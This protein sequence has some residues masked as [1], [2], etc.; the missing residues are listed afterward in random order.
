MSKD[1]SGR[2]D[3]D[4]CP[5]AD[6][7]IYYL[8]GRIQHDKKRFGP[9]FIGNWE[10]DGFSFLFFSRP[11]EKTVAT[12][13]DADPALVLMDA[14]QM[15]Y[16]Q[17]QGQRLTPFEAGGLRIIPPWEAT[18]AETENRDRQILLDPGV[19][20]GAGTHTTTQDCLEALQ[21]ACKDGAMDRVL[22]L[23]TGTGVLALAAVGL[24]CRRVVAVD[25]NLLAAET[26]WRNARLNRMTDRMAVICGRAEDAMGFTADLV[27][28]NIHF[29]VMKQL[30]GAEG[31]LTKKHF[32][33]S[34]LMRSQ[35]REIESD[36]LCLPVKILKRW[37]REGIWHT[38]YGTMDPA[39]GAD[40]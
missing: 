29:E 33:L 30:V 14:F 22:D 1:G 12:L 15:P 40:G 25:F 8:Q 24:G 28:A 21:L 11:N 13:V 23:G 7:Y 18:A 34:G 20:F 3:L 16:D 37:D 39:A 35:A 10:E 26:A 27:V 19:V 17:W 6:L 32:I 31:F 2:L 38:F 4:H 9:D 36:L 5:Y